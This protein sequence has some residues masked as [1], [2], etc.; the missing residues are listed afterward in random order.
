MQNAHARKCTVDPITSPHLVGLQGIYMR[1]DTASATSAAMLVL[2]RRP[3]QAN[4]AEFTTR[5]KVVFLPHAPRERWV[6][7]EKRCERRCAAQ[8]AAEA[9]KIGEALLLVGVWPLAVLAFV[10]VRRRRQPTASSVVVFAGAVEPS[11]GRAQ[12]VP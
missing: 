8:V 2:G 10:H 4:S 6:A 7:C 3:R 1:P 9:H 11:C 5:E 12:C